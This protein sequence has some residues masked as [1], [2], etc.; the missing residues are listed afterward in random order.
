VLG[1]PE[2]LDRFKS[3]YRVIPSDSGCTIRS[4]AESGEPEQWSITT[5]FAF[6]GTEQYIVG[7]ILDHEPVDEGEVAAACATLSLIVEKMHEP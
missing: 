4:A 2:L 1:D 3:S 6:A 7:V 5:G